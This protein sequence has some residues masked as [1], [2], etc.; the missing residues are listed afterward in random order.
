MAKK[1]SPSKT[2]LSKK[3]KTKD[4]S[5]V[6]GSLREHTRNFLTTLN[7]KQKILAGTAA[8]LLLA[9]LL[10]LTIKP[11][12][13]FALNLFSD[14]NVIVVVLDSTT[15]NPVV[16]VD[17]VLDST[18]G[19]TDEQGRVKIYGLD[20]GGHDISLAKE[21]YESQTG[22]IDIERN[23][24][25]FSFNMVPNGVELSLLGV[26]SITGT[27]LANYDVIDSTSALSTS[28]DEAGLAKLNVPPGTTELELTITLDGY[29]QT[30]AKYSLVDDDGNTLPDAELSEQRQIQ[31][32]QSG[33]HHFLTNR[34]GPIGL[35][36][37][38]YD[39]SDA[40][41]VVEDLGQR[42]GSIRLTLSPDGKFAV[43]AAPIKGERNSDGDIQ[44]ELYLVN[45][46][47]GENHLF[48]EGE[49]VRFRILK[50]ENDR[51]VY[52]VNL[53]NGRL[54]YRGKIKS[55]TFS[56]DSLSTH[57][58][59]NELF[60]GVYLDN[61]V[62]FEREFTRRINCSWCSEGYRNETKGR[63][64]VVVDLANDE[65]DETYPFS[66]P[67]PDGQQLIWVESRDGIG[68]LIVSTSGSLDGSST[69]DTQELAINY[70]V[71]W[72]DNQFLIVHGS[73]IAGK[74]GNFLVH[75]ES[76]KYQLVSTI[77]ENTYYY[78]HGYYGY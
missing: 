16:G 77:Y 8:I 59:E 25:E 64:F 19:R 46:E 66:N 11:L 75:V 47:T 9:G 29:N 45:L 24:Q 50:V 17:V 39:G 70:I 55:Y 44:N 32:V 71:H 54:T 37:S 73:E 49:D 40:S 15:E 23:E 43:V 48:D 56:S 20:Y 5:S 14:A 62:L 2:S 52:V 63:G 78:R 26:H 57:Y 58:K 74:S 31:L 65:L 30:T 72:I 51:V 60:D 7:K 28:A 42:R 67:S 36:G 61:R 68:T 35:W 18:A 13:L 33:R 10:I 21:A 12:R 3:S 22:S 6:S 38:N 53:S 4:K 69:V 27:P 41:A 1:K 34:D 76:G